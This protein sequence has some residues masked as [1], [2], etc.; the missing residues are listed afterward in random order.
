MNIRGLNLR[1]CTVPARLALER[2]AVD[3]RVLGSERAGVGEAAVGD[4]H[5]ACRVAARVC[6]DGSMRDAGREPGE[7]DR[8][9]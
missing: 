3:A 5:V 1:S 9:G 8:A 7:A 2:E 4:S 6:E